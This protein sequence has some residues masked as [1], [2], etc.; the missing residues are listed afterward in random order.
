[1][2]CI[3]VL[4]F[5]AFAG[6]WV[7]F[8]KDFETFVFGS[9]H[10]VLDKI[11]QPTVSMSRGQASSSRSYGTQAIAARPTFQSW[12]LMLE[13]SFAVNEDFTKFEATIWAVQQLKHRGLKQLFKPVTSTSY[14]HLFQSFYENLTYDCNWPNVLSSYIDDR[15]IEETVADIATALKCNAERPKADD[16]WIDCTSML[17]TEDIVRDICVG[18]FAN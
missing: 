7:A 18:Q 13:M 6:G 11:P 14:K 12:K 16:Q 10:Q 5:I 2:L 1:V 15:D 17:T 9:A 3:S 8:E 4:V